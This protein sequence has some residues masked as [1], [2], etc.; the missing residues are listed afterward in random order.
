VVELFPD[1]LLTPAAWFRSRTSTIDDWSLPEVVAAKAGQRVAVVLPARNEERTVGAIVERICRDLATPLLA[2]VDDVVVVDDG[3]TDETAR[4]AAAHG[5]RVV[6]SDDVLTAWPSRGGKGDAMWRGVAATD[7]DIVVFVDADLEE[8]DARFV[9]A[10]VGP[11]LA[12]PQ[13]GFVKAGY[14][15]PPLDPAT[16]SQGGGRVTELL[17]RPLISTFWPELSYVL[18]PLAGEYAARR[19]LL[20]RLPFRVGYGVDLGLLLDAFAV[21]GLEGLAQV[22]LRR[23]WHAH[24]DVKSLGRMSAEVLHTALDRLTREGRLHPDLA[25]G[26]VLI[27]PDRS[28]DAVRMVEHQVQTDERPP[29]DDIVAAASSQPNCQNATK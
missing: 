26:D 12:D 11:M 7:A 13:V 18:Q 27:Q 21:T 3:S 19:S 20:T 28:G 5:A 29:L 2:L 17:A 1:S 25:L 16:P 8:F 4:V 24:S 23:R 22:D 6:S 14:E 15:R 10:L 9:T